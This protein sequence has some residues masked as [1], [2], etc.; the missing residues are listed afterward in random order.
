VAGRGSK[1]IQHLYKRIF[2]RSEDVLRKR[3]LAA[4]LFWLFRLQWPVLGRC[5]A[6]CPAAAR[7]LAPQPAAPRCM[8]WW[9]TR[10]TP[11][12]RR[13][14]DSEVG[15]GKAQS[16]VS[17]SDGTYS[18]RGVA[19]GTYTLAWKRPA[20][21]LHQAAVRVTSGANLNQTPRWP[22]EAGAAGERLHGTRLAE[23][24]PGEQRQRAVIT[25]A[26]LGRAVGR[27]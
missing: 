21:P 3:L 5:A 12:Y 11:W 1:A 20:S 16:T 17:K 22:A 4:F 8:A 14:G 13:D 9:W 2:A 10:T 6:A 19:A 24:G 7:P 27:S 26:A 18:F 15:T 23:R 25:G